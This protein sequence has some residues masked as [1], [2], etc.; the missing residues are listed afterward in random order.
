MFVSLRKDQGAHKRNRRKKKLK[1]YVPYMW[2]NT[3]ES[4]IKKKNRHRWHAYRVELNSIIMSVF[5]HSVKA[6]SLSSLISHSSRARH[7]LTRLN[8]LPAHELC[9]IHWW[10]WKSLIQA[11]L[12]EIGNVHKQIVSRQRCSPLQL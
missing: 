3:R 7:A 1:S 10:H 6:H 11:V 8:S 5:C 12:R 9:C 2:E 4:F